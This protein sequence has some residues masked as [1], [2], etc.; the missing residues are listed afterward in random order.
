[1]NKLEL[2]H[3]YLSMIEDIIASNDYFALD[4]DTIDKMKSAVAYKKEIEHRI[5]KNITKDDE[6]QKAGMR[7]YQLLEN[8]TEPGPEN[9]YKAFMADINKRFDT[10]INVKVLYYGMPFGTLPKQRPYR[11]ECF[12]RT[13][14][15]SRTEYVNIIAYTQ[16][17]A[18]RIFENYMKECGYYNSIFAHSQQADY[19]GPLYR[20]EQVGAIIGANWY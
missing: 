3:T 15:D 19:S 2:A 12:Y 5:S 14:A 20:Y 8:A 13:E 1:M 18:S 4:Q 10:C 9:T 17:E 16:E 6:I 11:Y 7:I